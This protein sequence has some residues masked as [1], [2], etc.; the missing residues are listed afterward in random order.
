MFISN[1]GVEH[2]KKR[3]RTVAN[4]L[5][6]HQTKN[7]FINSLCNIFRTFFPFCEDKSSILI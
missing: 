4:Q 6:L 5:A 1:E 7:I 2:V 3:R